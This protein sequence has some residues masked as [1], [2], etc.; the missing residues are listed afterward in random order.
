MHNLLSKTIQKER[1]KKKEMK[2]LGKNR[3]KK[4]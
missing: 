4:M 3:K 1:G 2:D